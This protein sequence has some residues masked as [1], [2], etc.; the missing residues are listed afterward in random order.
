MQ[1]EQHVEHPGAKRMSCSLD[2]GDPFHNGLIND[3]GSG[4]LEE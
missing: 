2:P 1:I 3:F 4:S